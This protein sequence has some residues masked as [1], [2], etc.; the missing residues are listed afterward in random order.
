MTWDREQIAQYLH[1]PEAIT[2][3]QLQPFRDDLIDSFCEDIRIVEMY[4][5]PQGD[6]V[7]AL[8]VTTLTKRET[9]VTK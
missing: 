4:Y 5:E 8:F 1:T 7:S 2:D 3:Y 9:A 6:T